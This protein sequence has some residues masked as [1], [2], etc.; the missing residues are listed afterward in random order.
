M[1]EPAACRLSL[2]FAADA[3]VAV[4]LRR[5]PSKWVAVTKWDTS[6]DR[7]EEGQWFH[8][9]IYGE[10]CGLSPDGSLFVYF[11]TKYKAGNKDDGYQDTYTAV[12]KPPYLTALAMWPE[13]STW[14]GG[15]R[16]IDN[17]TLGLAY[18]AGR[19]RTPHN[20]KTEIFM[21]PMPDHH[22]NHS[23]RGL[24]IEGDLDYYNPDRAF[25]DVESPDGCEW[26]G[27][28]QSGRKIHTRGGALYYENQSHSEVLLRNFN[29]VERH[30][31]VAPEWAQNW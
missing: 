24:T 15:G 30:D 13:G 17:Q 18:G 31:V 23:P 26:A 9:R 16:F 19:T 12:S 20:G 14:G 7:F 2:I 4:V 29:S 22:P 1:K 25:H 10:R 11:A 3:P 21:A 6:N 28:D 27:K 8:G 5:G